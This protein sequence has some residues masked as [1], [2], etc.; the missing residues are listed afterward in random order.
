MN[1]EKIGK[2]IKELREQSNMTQQNL[3]EKIP[4]SRQAISKWELGKTL[5]EHS[6]LVKLST[7]F[8]VSIDEILAGEKNSDLNVVL[9]LYKEKITSTKIIKYFSLILIFLIFAF[10]LHYFFHHFNS[11]KI[12]KISGENE[13][14]KIENGLFIKTNEKIYFNIGKIQMDFTTNIKKI[15]LFYRKDNN[16]YF[17]YSSDDLHILINDYYGYEEYFE[18]NKIDSIIDKFYIRII[19][20]SREYIVKLNLQEDYKNNNLYIL[21]K[22]QISDDSVSSENNFNNQNLVNKIKTKFKKKDDYYKYNDKFESLDVL[23]TYHLDTK[24]LSIETLRKNKVIS[25]WIYNL[26]TSLLTYNNYNDNYSLFCVIDLKTQ[27]CI[28][29]ECDKFE[30]NKNIFYEQLSKIN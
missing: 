18:F 8:N 25:D 1:A 4:I 9:E 2:F 29:G 12:Y 11:V 27:K 5:P 30:K 16:D 23:Y 28:S 7:I 22:I 3:A 13:N 6:A 26:N 19:D 14:I 24:I 21:K 17:V 15:E 20:E 10:L